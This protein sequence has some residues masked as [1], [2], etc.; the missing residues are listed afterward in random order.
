MKYKNEI[1]INILNPGDVV[2]ITTT[3][4]APDE[5]PKKFKVNDI[6]KDGLLYNCSITCDGY[7]FP[8]SWIK[9]IK[10]VK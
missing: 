5:C 3:N 8:Y 10:I 9:E 7:I 1:I 6:L 4:S 2:Q